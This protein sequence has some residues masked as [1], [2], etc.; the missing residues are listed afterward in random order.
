MFLYMLYYAN[1]SISNLIVTQHKLGK[2]Q[3]MRRW[4]EREDS[5]AERE[6]EK[7]IQRE[8]EGGEGERHAHTCTDIQ[9]HTQTKSGSK[10]C[11]LLCD[12]FG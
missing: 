12:Y 8:R 3:N 2:T 11:L 6:R 4:G 5:Q 1:L 9:T 7:W 10:L